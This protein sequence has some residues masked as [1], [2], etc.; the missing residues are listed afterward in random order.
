MIKE[1]IDIFL[2]SEANIAIEKIETKENI[3]IFLDSEAN[4]P[5]EEIESDKIFSNVDLSIYKGKDGY[6]PIKGVDYFIEE[7]I[8][9]LKEIFA[10]KDHTHDNMGG[11]AKA[12]C[13]TFKAGELKVGQGLDNKDYKNNVKWIDNV[14][15]VNAENLNAIEEKLF[16]QQHYVGELPPADTDITWYDT[17]SSSID[18]TLDSLIIKE[19]KSIISDMS[20]QISYLTEKVE[21]LLNMQGGDLP[22][23]DN[24]V[25]TGNFLLLENGDLILLEDGNKILLEQQ[26]SVLKNTTII[27]ENGLNILIEYGKNIIKEGENGRY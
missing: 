19:L 1:N 16:K 9:A 20:S 13:G 3:D 15:P 4:I 25:V 2:D 5:I 10:L 6:T 14:T 27:T 8:N 12:I 23:D 22:G 21:Y 17:T 24:E 7:D 11:S 18:E 26:Q